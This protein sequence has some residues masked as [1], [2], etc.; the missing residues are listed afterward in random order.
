MY[1]VSFKLVDNEPIIVSAHEKETI[2]NETFS[3]NSMAE[4]MLQ[5]QIITTHQGGGEG[6]YYGLMVV[7]S[8][9]IAL[10]SKITKK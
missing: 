9:K 5:A 2:V 4:Q 7:A 1:R 8:R 6:S 10:K 3:Q